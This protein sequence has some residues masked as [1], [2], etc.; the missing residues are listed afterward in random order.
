MQLTE[1]LTELET[2]GLA[3]GNRWHS[4]PSQ[5]YEI[6][7]VHPSDYLLNPEELSLIQTLLIERAQVQPVLN[8]NQ[9]WRTVLLSF[10][11]LSRRLKT[12]LLFRRNRRASELETRQNSGSQGVQPLGAPDLDRTIGFVTP[13][14]LSKFFDISL[15]DVM[16]VVDEELSELPT[17]FPL[18]RTELVA[19]MDKMESLAR[20]LIR[21]R[22]VNEAWLVVS[23]MVHFGKRTSIVD[24][25]FLHCEE[26]RDAVRADE[27][28]FLLES[29]KIFG[30]RALL[31]WSCV[32]YV[33]FG[34]DAIERELAE[35]LSDEKSET[36][37]T[38][39]VE[40]FRHRG[41]DP[42]QPQVAQPYDAAR[43]SAD[44]QEKESQAKRF[45]MDGEID[46]ALK[47]VWEVLTVMPESAI[48]FL[49]FKICR[50]IQDESEAE[51]LKAWLESNGKFNDQARLEFTA[52]KIDL[53]GRGA[54]EQDIDE[55]L[56]GKPDN[57]RRHVTNFLKLTS[58]YP[59]KE[60]EIARLLAHGEIQAALDKACE[61]PKHAPSS[62]SLLYVF[63][64]CRENLAAA[65]AIKLK[66]AV[67]KVR[68]LTRVELLVWTTTQIICKKISEESEHISRLLD[69]ASDEE[70]S[71]H[72][73]Q[74]M[75]DAGLD[76][77]R[78]KSLM[79]TEE[80]LKSV[81]WEAP[82]VEGARSSELRESMLTSLLSE[83]VELLE[84]LGI[85]RVR[86]IGE[87]HWKISKDQATQF[88][89]AWRLHNARFPMS[90]DDPEGR[91]RISKYHKIEG[92]R[93]LKLKRP[94]V[95][96]LVDKLRLRRIDDEF[97]SQADSVRLL[98]D[99]L[100]AK[101]RK[102]HH[103]EPPPPP[104]PP[105]NEVIPVKTPSIVMDN[106][107]Y[108]DQSFRSEDFAGCSARNCNFTRANLESVNFA[109]AV[110]DGAIF[111]HANLAGAILD[112][113]SVVGADFS[114]VDLTRTS[115]KDVDLTAAKID[116][117]SLPECKGNQ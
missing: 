10:R 32:S 105:P 75:I 117:A 82:D 44:I 91:G 14:L 70:G 65:P 52:V 23:R 64:W 17:S 30:S 31:R 107:N 13:L 24:L 42:L 94:D 100:K 87:L 46:Q 21:R 79:I 102:S 67:E 113:A 28:R 12:Q 76:I 19:F 49:G 7:G 45:F 73:L 40:E 116:G 43:F 29:L 81:V 20:E 27:L 6:A 37:R 95:I 2:R 96:A 35:L 4:I 62:P 38:N 25:W 93:Q 66:N 1:L 54:M 74:S 114:Y 48:V 60:E 55:L 59:E 72:A 41:F 3:I 83:M 26:S 50:S 86:I 47:L 33:V 22:F 108:S 106:I 68:P 56:R 34:R 39:V 9:W 109:G 8:T 53:L 78:L 84:S 18:S 112:G 88:W 58:S 85:T 98:S 80:A 77:D 104:P 63:E 115:L 99:L 16:N 92:L 103:V 110:L 11:S 57:W 15:D 97:L 61:L 51:R 36:F 111:S 69:S 71:Q 101:P 5:V 90:E 89:K